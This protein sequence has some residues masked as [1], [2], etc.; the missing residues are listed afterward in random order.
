MQRRRNTK[1]FRLRLNS[2]ST[3]SG[4]IQFAGIGQPANIKRLVKKLLVHLPGPVR[5]GIRQGGFIGCLF[6]PK[7]AQLAQTAR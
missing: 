5:V 4:E 1:L 7:M 3:V 2:V 6:Y